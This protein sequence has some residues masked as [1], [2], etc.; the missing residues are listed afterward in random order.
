MPGAAALGFGRRLHARRGEMVCCPYSLPGDDWLRRSPAEIT[1]GRRRVGDTAEQPHAGS[2]LDC[3][4]AG[5]LSA[6]DADRLRYAGPAQPNGGK[7]S[8]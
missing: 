1:D 4:S 6:L 5:D 8:E 3:G 2:P 7:N